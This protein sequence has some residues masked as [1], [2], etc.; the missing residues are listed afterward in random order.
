MRSIL[1]STVAWVSLVCTVAAP[2]S[3]PADI[4]N[5]DKVDWLDVRMLRADWLWPGPGPSDI[6]N[7]GDVNFVDFAILA[8][9]WRWVG[10]PGDTVLIPGGEFWMGD[11]YDEMP[12]ANTHLVYVDSF[13]LS[14]CETT[15]QRYC[16]Y[17][18]SAYSQ[19][20]IEVS[21][22]VVY[23]YGGA[24]AYCD[25]N[26]SSSHSRITWDDGSFDVVSG[27]QDHPMVMVTWYGAVAYCDYYGYRLPTEAEWEC[28]A[29]GGK[30][31]PYCAY[32]WGND[33]D[34]SKANYQDSGDP[35][36][37]GAHPWT[38]PVGYYDGG[39]IPAGTDMA[40]GYGLYD[41]AG[42]V[43]EWCNDWYGSNYYDISPYNNPQGPVSGTCRVVRGGS[44]FIAAHYCR[45]ANR[46]YSIPDSRII[47]YGFRVVMD[48]E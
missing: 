34:G 25:T 45:V 28:A 38:T 37:T 30:H 26:T 33:I 23:S 3:N 16:N 29:R 32:P 42:N 13:Y 6:D 47:T 41:V 31:D 44:W 43:W 39:Q 4:N 40:N 10:Q 48:A 11:H 9:S 7:S 35:Y 14:R 8:D 2:A 20:L 27:K 15:N 12:D 46:S 19:G 1:V 36:E 22:G 5:D 21:D 24:N 17:L 18:N